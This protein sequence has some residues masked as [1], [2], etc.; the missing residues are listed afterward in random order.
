MYKNKNDGN[1]KYLLYGGADDN[2]RLAGLFQIRAVISGEDDAFSFY[3]ARI[4]CK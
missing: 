3:S 2:S 4:M 1:K